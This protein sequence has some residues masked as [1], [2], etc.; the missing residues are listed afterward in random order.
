MSG[1]KYRMTSKPTLHT[2]KHNLSTDTSGQTIIRSQQHITQQFLDD[3]KR[4]R[5]ASDAQTRIGENM[6]VCSIPVA[7]LEKWIAEGFNPMACRHEDDE[8]Q[9]KVL[10]E[11]QRRLKAEG[12]EYFLNTNKTV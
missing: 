4:A 8:T 2:L 12:F 10:R 5:A 9:M 1:S 6:T 3:R 7:L 11:V